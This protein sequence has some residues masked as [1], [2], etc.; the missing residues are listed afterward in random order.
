[1]SEEFRGEEDGAAEDEQEDSDRDGLV[2]VGV[3]QAVNGGCKSLGNALKATRE[4][5]RGPNSPIPRAKASAG[6]TQAHPR[7]RYGTRTI[8]RSRPAPRVAATSIS[9]ESIASNAAIA[10]RM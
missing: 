5:D 10:P 8:R 2:E 3:E 9:V 7:E 6:G 1:M 4:Q